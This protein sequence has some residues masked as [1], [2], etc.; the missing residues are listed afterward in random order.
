M[1]KGFLDKIYYPFV[2]TR[3]HVSIMYAFILYN[4]IENHTNPKPYLPLVLAFSIWNYAL[5]LFDR[6]YDAH[7]DNLSSTKESLMGKHN[8]FFLIFSFL[9]AFVPLPILL[10]SNFSLFPFILFLPVTFLYNLRIFPGKKAVKHFFFI[11]NLYSAIFIWT[12]PVVCV[13]KFYLHLPY[14][15]IQIYLWFWSF[16]FT[17]LIGEIIW[18]IR[19]M[20]GDK[21]EGLKTVPIVLG[22]QKTKIIIVATILFVFVPIS[23]WRHQFDWIF[24]VIF[25]LYGIFASPKIPKWIYHL[26]IFVTILKFLYIYLG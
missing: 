2:K 11:K 3:L 14:T 18:D 12:L 17:V 16:V 8:R 15:F 22:L 7:L 23:L 21:Q 26:P 25:L 13:L 4:I 19:D 24:V 1:D 5:Y 10:L 9:L 20:D 6:A